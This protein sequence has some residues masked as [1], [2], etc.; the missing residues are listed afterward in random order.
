MGEKIL[1]VDDE[2]NVLEAIQRQLRSRFD[3]KTA[4]SGEE[5]LEVLRTSGPF[6]II[7]SD[8]RMPG[9]D[10][11]QLL[12]QVKDM[13][14]DMVRIMLTGNADQET[15]VEAVNAGQIFRF[16][17]KPCS[18]A[19]LATALA[20]AARQ[21]KLINAEKEL[22]NETLK[23]SMKVLS[24]LLSQT[25]ATIFG[26]GGR[27]KELMT[28]LCSQDKCR[29][30]WQYEIAGLMSQLG[31][32]SLP[33]DILHKLYA[34]IKLSPEERQMY[35]HHPEV[36]RR[37]FAHIPRMEL[38]AGMVAMQLSPMS[39]Y[40]DEAITEEDAVVCRGAQML[41][42]AI[43]YDLFRYQGMTHRDI[44]NKMKTMPRVYNPE[45]VK[46]LEGLKVKKEQGALVNLKVK[47]IQTGMTAQE[48]VFAN[49]GVLIIPQGQVVTWTILQ[50][51]DNFAKQVGI[52]EPVCMRMPSTEELS[53]L[54]N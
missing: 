21:Y 33:S 12:T 46:T 16:L 27:I 22:L 19:T 3:I 34:G 35:E 1:L 40:E 42:V 8:M 31:C 14:P 24:E 53:A 52:K 37:L 38:V 25:N 48:D 5:A 6:S 18:T 51:L 32:I 43:D 4:Q 13:Y 29:H 15:A 36:G 23:G 9:M 49:N 39:E 20:L 28:H 41:K 54:E 45:I 11:I 44:L 7:V 26:A 47:D 50:G 30:S 2:V 17:N 10:G